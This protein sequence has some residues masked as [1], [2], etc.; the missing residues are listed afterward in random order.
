MSILITSVDCER[1]FSFQNRIKTDVRNRL[2]VE[3]VNDLIIMSKDGDKMELF[4]LAA[5]KQLFFETKK[6]NAIEKSKRT[7]D[8]L[9][10]SSKR[11]KNR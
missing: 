5:N 10:S 11:L 7:A 8:Y 6:Q 2:S 3:S 4:Y 1:I 9:A